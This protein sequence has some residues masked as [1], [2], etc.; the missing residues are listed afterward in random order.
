MARLPSSWP[1]S[2]GRRVGGG[3]SR[4]A[5]GFPFS[6][7]GVCSAGRCSSC[8]LLPQATEAMVEEGCYSNEGV[9]QGDFGTDFV[10]E[11]L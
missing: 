8:L 6:S 9:V 5:G 3:L 1:W 4:G 7:R 2:P 11:L 10:L